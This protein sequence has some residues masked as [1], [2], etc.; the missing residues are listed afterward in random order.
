MVLIL[1][2]ALNLEKQMQ[3]LKDFFFRLFK[4]LCQLEA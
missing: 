4:L 1:L 3:L 2:R